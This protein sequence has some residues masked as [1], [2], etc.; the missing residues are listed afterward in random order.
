MLENISLKTEDFTGLQC[1]TDTTSTCLIV[2]RALYNIQE[3]TWTRSA[4]NKLEEYSK[5]RKICNWWNL[6]VK[7]QQLQFL[8]FNVVCSHSISVINMIEY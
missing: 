2:N 3:T 5:L 7:K 1:A 6:R 8:V 4:K